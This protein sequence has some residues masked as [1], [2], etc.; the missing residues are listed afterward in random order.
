MTHVCSAF[1]YN[2][3]IITSFHLPSDIFRFILP[4]F[5]F[6]LLRH[7]DSKN[8]PQ[9]LLKPECKVTVKR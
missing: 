7:E 1:Q 8:S 5:G 4:S 6:K 2:K 3:E 9:Y